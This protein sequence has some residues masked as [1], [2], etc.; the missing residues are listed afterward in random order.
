MDIHVCSQTTN[1]SAVVRAY[2]AKVNLNDMWRQLPVA[3]G[4]Y[5][6][7]IRQTISPLL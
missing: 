4:S 3:N 6:F 5:P 2:H 7:S 1:A